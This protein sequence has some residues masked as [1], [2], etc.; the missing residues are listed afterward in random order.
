MSDGEYIEIKGGL[1]AGQEYVSEG[2]FII[3]ADILKAG[4]EHVH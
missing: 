3:K 2:S 1:K 4:A